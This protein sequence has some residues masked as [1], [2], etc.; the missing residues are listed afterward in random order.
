LKH[1]LFQLSLTPAGGRVTSKNRKENNK[2]GAENN[3]AGIT[4]D[5]NIV[6]E[7][8]ERVQALYGENKKIT[9]GNYDK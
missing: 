2:M 4:N 7:A 9:D 1:R 5:E 6:R 8:A 3:A